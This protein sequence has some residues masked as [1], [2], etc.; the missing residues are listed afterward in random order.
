[1]T[2]VVNAAGKFLDLSGRW[3]A[4]FPDARVFGTLG[5][6][7]YAAREAARREQ[8]PTFVVVGYGL[9]TQRTATSYQNGLDQSHATARRIPA[10]VSGR[11][12]WK[13]TASNEAYLTAKGESARAPRARVYSCMAR[14]RGSRFIWMVT[15][16]GQAV[17][18]CVDPSTAQRLGREFAEAGR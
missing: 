9:S 3:V 4:E 8:A 12:T 10:P 6:A 17:A 14:P 1:V 13:W 18:V 7:R 2:V 16:R 11:A 5:S 15:V